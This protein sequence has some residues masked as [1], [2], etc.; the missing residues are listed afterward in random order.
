MRVQYY[1]FFGH[2]GITESHYGRTF[3]DMKD[4]LFKGFDQQWA[5]ATFSVPVTQTYVDQGLMEDGPGAFTLEQSEEILE[6][7]I[8]KL[9]P[10]VVD[11]SRKE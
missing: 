10:L 3:I 4:R 8:R 1:T 9:G 7:F 11:R 6:Q 5:Y 2:T